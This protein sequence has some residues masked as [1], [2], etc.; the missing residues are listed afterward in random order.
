MADG[1][2]EGVVGCRGQDTHRLRHVVQARSIVDVVRNLAVLARIVRDL[3]PV[4]A[5]RQ[6]RHPRRLGKDGRT[7]LVSQGR[8]RV[9]V[10]PDKPDPVRRLQQQLGKLGLLRRV[11]PSRP[12]RVHLR[13]HRQRHDQLH[14]GVV[15]HVPAPGHLDELVRQPDVLRIRQHIFRRRH[16]NQLDRPLVPEALERP[17]TNGPHELDRRQPVV[18]DEHGMDRLVAAE[19]A[20]HRVERLVARRARRAQRHA[21]TGRRRRGRVAVHGEVRERQG[22]GEVP[23]VGLLVFRRAHL[24]VLDRHSGVNGRVGFGRRLSHPGRACGENEKRS[25][26]VGMISRRKFRPCLAT[27][28][29]GSMERYRDLANYLCTME[30]WS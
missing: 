11:P 6:R 14:V 22:H 16:R 20:D 3:H 18:G 1:E 12:N 8:H 7:D 26:S 30:M 25:K 27:G 10:G 5:P 28:I 29:S 19:L 23:V 15:V 9:L 21:R 4:S 24:A 2:G 17:V 13:P